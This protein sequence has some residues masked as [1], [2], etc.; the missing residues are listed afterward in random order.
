[1]QEMPPLVFEIFSL[2]GFLV[3]ALGFLVFGFGVGR[4]TFDAYKKAIWQ[5]QIALVLGFFGLL[6][7]LANFT[8]P[9]STGMFVIGVS[10]ALLM[11]G[12]AEKEDKED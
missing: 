4:F 9:G 6:V 8:S 10:V 12:K 3:S 1:M 5:V 11:P 2:L 7:G